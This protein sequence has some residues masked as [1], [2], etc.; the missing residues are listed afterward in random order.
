[1]APFSLLSLPSFLPASLCVFLS[2]HLSLSLSPQTP[3]SLGR[4]GTLSSETLSSK[5]HCLRRATRL[6]DR[7]LI[8]APVARQNHSVS[9]LGSGQPLSLSQPITVGGVN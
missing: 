9:F 8:P 3:N 7:V 2:L 4:N 1:M 6:F 5:L